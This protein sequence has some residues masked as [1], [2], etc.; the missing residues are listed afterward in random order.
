MYSCNV[1]DE[2][3]QIGSADAAHQL[4]GALEEQLASQ[5]ESY[6]L[7]VVGGSALLALD[8]VR[9][10]TQDVDIVALIEERRLVSAVELP[11]GLLAARD[12]VARDFGVSPEWLNS[13]PAELLRV[14]L[15]DGFEQRW[16][17]QSYGP[18]L[19]VRWASRYDQ[20]HLKLYAA[21]DQAGKHLRDLEVLAPQRDELIAAARWARA[22]DPSEGFEVVL[23]EALAYFGIE[24]ADLGD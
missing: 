7:A 22:H 11:A 10:A 6:D 17:T 20:I 12:R 3:H 23:R 18:A 16:E 19:T 14:G 2:S 21:V 9:R 8:L 5:A 15:P 4:L 1:V 13:G 24:D